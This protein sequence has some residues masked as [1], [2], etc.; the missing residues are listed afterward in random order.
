LVDNLEMKNR[1][2]LYRSLSKV[3]GLAWLFLIGLQLGHASAQETTSHPTALVLTTENRTVKVGETVSFNLKLIDANYKP[4]SAG[5]ELRVSIETQLPSGKTESRE[6]TIEPGTSSKTFSMPVYETG[7][8]RIRAKEQSLLEGGDVLYAAPASSSAHPGPMIRSEVASANSSFHMP[9]SLIAANLT[10]AIALIH[11]A[12]GLTTAVTNA[13]AEDPPVGASQTKLR[14]KLL[15]TPERQL[16]ANGKDRATIQAIVFDVDNGPPKIDVQ[17]VMSNTLGNMKPMKLLIPKGE[18]IGTCE[19]T[20]D[21]VGLAKVSCPFSN[22]PIDDEDGYVDVEFGPAITSLRIRAS[23]PNI[24]LVDEPDIFV[25][26]V[27]EKGTPL[28]TDRNRQVSLRIDT[29]NGAF[30]SNAFTIK[31]G[32]SEGD[33]KFLPEQV[34][35]VIVTA[36]SDNLQEESASVQVT[37]PTLLVVLAIFGGALGGLLAFW[38]HHDKPWWRY[39]VGGSVTGLVAYWASLLGVLPH[40]PMS[41]PILLNW[42]IALGVAILGG[43][44]GTK[45]F[46]AIFGVFSKN[47]PPSRMSSN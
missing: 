32:D 17:L 42:F 34:G 28:A 43:W 46:P 1:A 40:F 39:V 14:L 36:F 45:I 44:L 18:A 47:D 15:S 7:I 6:I 8:I 37:W 27:D 21:Q 25:Q 41:R 30:A 24:S 26:L 13:S 11:E 22:P 3:A 12:R 5:K 29:G 9:A 31:K 38:E 23:P 33:A 4:A 10:V 35:Q 19:L 2:Y 16:L 20:S